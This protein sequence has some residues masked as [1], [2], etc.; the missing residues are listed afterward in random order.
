LLQA[1]RLD[2][3]DQLIEGGAFHQG[4]EVRQLVKVLSRNDWL[5]GRLRHLN[6][7]DLYAFG[8]AVLSCPAIAV[9]SVP[10]PTISAAL[11]TSHYSCD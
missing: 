7:F 9:H 2:I 8:I 10:D 6:L 3:G 11:P 5:S 4:E 1:V